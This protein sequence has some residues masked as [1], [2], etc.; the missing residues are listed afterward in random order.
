MDQIRVFH[1]VP[2]GPE[3]FLSLPGPLSV[4]IRLINFFPNSQLVTS[5]TDV[6]Q[7]LSDSR[8]PVS[9][10]SLFRKFQYKKRLVTGFSIGFIL[11]FARLPSESVVH[12]HYSRSVSTAVISLYC[13]VSKK[14]L[15]V[16]QTHGSVKF[17]TNFW[18]RIFD[19]FVT[20]R[21]F[22]KANIIVALQE[23]ERNHLERIGADSKK[24]AIIP[25]SILPLSDNEREKLS[26]TYSL[27]PQVI[28]VGHLRPSKQ[29]LRFLE[30]ATLEKYSHCNFL[31][32]GPDGGD[33]KTLLAHI[34]AGNKNNIQ[35]L[36]SLQWEE[37][38]NLYCESDV[39]LSPALD[40]PF[41]LSFLDGVARGCI[42]IASQ[43]FNNWVELKQIGILIAEDT[44]LRSLE[45][46]LDAA[47]E[48]I[49]KGILTPRNCNESVEKVYGPEA[50]WD[51]WNTLYSK[52]GSR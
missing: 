28:F 47:L 45:T 42:G 4:A 9:K 38:S 26:R 1:F 33:L 40:A 48:I 6:K 30:V 51:R 34:H 35:Y 29:V 14:S 23:N 44:G 7:N 52:V 25:N 12:L 3:S 32:A 37:L 10:I 18:K 22:K 17:G 20:R 13:S 27:R 39:I 16:V 49:S 5:S 36:G 50:I 19:Y 31:I 46:Q 41:E 24:I 8:I 2:D 43:E 21:L 11:K 15:S